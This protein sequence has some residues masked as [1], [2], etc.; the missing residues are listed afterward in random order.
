MGEPKSACGLCSE[1]C[2][3]MEERQN[4][5]YHNFVTK[6]C[7]QFMR[8]QASHCPWPV[9]DLQHDAK[10][11]GLIFLQEQSAK[12][13]ANTFDYGKETVWD[14]LKKQKK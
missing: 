8:R 3:R 11:Y 1:K 9:D 4:L 12:R 7:A 14:Q 6:N 2:I 13:I 5:C 10:A